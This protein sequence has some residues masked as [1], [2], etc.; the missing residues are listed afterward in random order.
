MAELATSVI[1]SDLERSIIESNHLQVVFDPD[2]SS[3][4]PQRA[5]WKGQHHCVTEYWDP[6]TGHVPEETRAGEV[7][8]QYQMGVSHYSVLEHAF[9]RVDCTGWGHDTVMQLRTHSD[10]SMLVQS[11]RYTGKRFLK[12]ANGVLPV[13]DAFY[14]RPCGDYVD[15]NGQRYTI[16][17]EDLEKRKQASLE[18]CR[19]YADAVAQGVAEED[20]RNLLTQNIKQQFGFAGNLKDIFHMLDQR[21][22]ADAQLECRIFSAM[23]M[24][25][26][27]DWAPQVG[28]WYCAKRY[29]KARLA[30]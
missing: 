4:R 7:I 15:R 20:A 9:F 17:P 19:R 26:I 11:S 21:S 28:S 29:G 22:L 24:N 6:T 5:I 2:G 30:P 8:V 1:L 27:L 14:F 10:S 12:V 16:A 23:V 13:E 18:S 3:P 25:H